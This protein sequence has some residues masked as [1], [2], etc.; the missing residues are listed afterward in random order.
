MAIKKY[1]DDNGVLYLW[2]K[3][4]ELVA[5]AQGTTDY[6]LLEN[7]PSINGITLQGNRTTADLNID[8]PTKVSQLTNDSGYLTST[9][10]D[11]KITAKVPTSVSQLTNDSG[12]LTSTE[13][14]TKITAK[15]PTSVSQLTNDSKYQS[16][17]QV[18]ALIA[19]AVAD[20]TQFDYQIVEE[21][22]EIGT[23][24]TIYLISAG[25]T[26]QQLYKEY[27]WIGTKY[28][29]FGAPI[30]LSGYVKSEEL[31]AITNAEIDTITNN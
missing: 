21:L 12:Y 28:E 15:V 19:A 14:D 8:I 16:D 27:I 23:K 13:V 31:V 3:I 22:P 11:T 6:T 25:T 2:G 1:L 29:E 10:V 17:T 26:E 7:K 9:E 18:A 5:G 24:G 4:K 30:D 20:I